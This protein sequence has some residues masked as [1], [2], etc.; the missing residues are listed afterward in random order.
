VPIGGQGMN[1]G[2]QDAFNL[3]WKLAGVL[4]GSLRPSILDS[5]HAERNPVAASLING[6]DIAYKGV[7]H[8]SEIRQ[9]AARLFG[10]FLMRSARVQDVM[11]G[12]LEE[13]NVFYTDTPINLDLGGAGGPAPG[14]RVL[15]AAVV[16]ATDQTTTSLIALLRIAGWTVLLFGG[17][18]AD[19]IADRISSRF[20]SRVTTWLIRESQDC[21]DNTRTLIDRLRIAHGR[22]GVTGPAFF[23]LRPDTY[24]AARGP[25]SAS[26]RLVEHL[27]TIFS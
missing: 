19:E 11:R 8:P 1:T 6:T 16:R 23:L 12:T 25:L 9:H 10:P 4:D 18:N 3:G 14:E 17:L 20:G 24:G 2:I 26:D 7:L 27:D 21:G 15:D 22:Y 5:Y 13:L